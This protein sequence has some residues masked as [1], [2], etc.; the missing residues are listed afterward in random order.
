MQSNLDTVKPNDRGELDI[1]SPKSIG[2]NSDSD[3][4]DWELEKYEPYAKDYWS[5]EAIPKQ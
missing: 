1:G 4:Y 5:I 2:C 3:L